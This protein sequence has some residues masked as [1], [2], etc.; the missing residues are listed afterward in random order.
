MA[1]QCSLSGLRLEKLLFLTVLIMQPMA[2]SGEELTGGRKLYQ[3]HCAGCHGDQGDGLGPAASFLYPKP[4]NFQLGKFKL[5]S[6]ENSVPSEADLDA[7]LVRGMP[8]SSMPSWAQLSEAD[9]KLLIAEIYRLTAEGARQTYL[10]TLRT[11]EELTDEELAAEDV[12]AEVA[13]FV[14]GRITPSS[15]VE[16]PTLTVADVLAVERGR[17]LFEQKGCASCHGVTG[18]GDGV[19]QMLDDDGTPTRPRDLTKGIYKGGH[20]V[21]S[22]FVRVSR[23]MPGTPMPSAPTLTPEESVDLVHFLRSL[24][25]EEQRNSVVL[26]RQRLPVSLVEVAPESS[27]DSAWSEIPATKVQSVPLWWRD[28][29]DPEL[30]YQA[31]RDGNTLV[32]RLSWRDATQNSSAV[33]PDEFDDMAA[34]ELYQGD[35]EPFLG[36]GAQQ[37]VVELWAW[38]AGNDVRGEERSQLDDYP[39]EGPVYDR[40]AGVQGVPDFITARAVGNPIAIRSTSAARLGGKG[41]GSSTF[42]VRPSQVVKANASWTDGQWTVTFSRPLSGQGDG[43]NISSGQDCSIAFAVWDGQVRERG[44]YKNVTMWNDL[45]IK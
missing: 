38:R 6:T 43:V 3:Q 28:R 44:G 37:G 34:L 30:Q 15:A 25:S 27:D 16:M 24:S 42:F 45:E 4:R 31:A 35:A 2:A 12:Q 14:E 17:I 9:R 11:E 33:K 26:K 39:F 1:L 10:A 40:L 7:V 32:V 22:L 13:E 8:G 36:M 19:K 5:V 20:D 23:G 21:A 41:P 18:K 29:E